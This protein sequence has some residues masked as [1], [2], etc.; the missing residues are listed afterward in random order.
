MAYRPTG[1]RYVPTIPEMLRHNAARHRARP[2]LR[3]WADGR[4][5]AISYGELLA[6]VEEFGAGLAALGLHKGDK[7]AIAAENGPRWAIAYLA[8]VAAGGIGVPIY[9]ELDDR[10]INGLI[11][12]S[13]SRFALLSSKV[14]D[15]TARHL[16]R[17]EAVIVTDRGP[18]GTSGELP[19]RR[20]L[21]H[22]QPPAAL[23]SFEEVLGR[24]TTESRAAFAQVPVRANDLAS[25]VYTSGTTGD[26]KGVMLSHRNIMSNAMAA[27][28]VVKANERDRFLQVLPM[29]HTF[30]FTTGLVAPLCAGA[31]VG[32]END[33]KRIR[34]RMFEMRATIFLG[35][36][37]L[38]AVMYRT[39]L[40]RIEAEGQMPAFQKGLALV[41]TVKRT[42]GVNI[43]RLVFR[44]LHQRLGGSIRLLASGGAALP[45]DVARRYA[46]LGILLIQGWGL[47]E[48]SPVC[49][50]PAFSPL[51]FYFTSHY[52]RHAASV[53]QALPGV[54]IS[55]ID[56][57]EKGIFAALHDEGELVVKGPN[58]TRGYYNNE[59]ATREIK[60]GEWLRTGDI[61]H[62][63]RE[64]NV[65]ITGRA[66]YVIVLSSGEKV[67]P[68]ELEER[69]EQSSLVGDICV[70][71][72]QVKKFLRGDRTEVVAVVYPDPIAVQ[73]RAASEGVAPTEEGIHRWVS[74]DIAR[75]QEDTPAY[76]TVTDVVL[77]DAPLPKTPLRK[78]RRG[79]V[80]GE[81]H[82]FDVRKF[83][84]TEA[85][86]Q[87]QTP[88]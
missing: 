35:V 53:G 72:R 24:A 49:A 42:T 15:K 85:E 44:A 64:G 71:G 67:Y 25:I 19:A 6:E 2:A 87:A 34:E 11:H 4:Y 41:E 52:E 59:A 70:V 36:P 65:Y 10:E 86:Q 33:L 88:A 51:K 12:E 48:A 27:I 74:E 63:D 60:I 62:I 23:L 29:H 20:H 18:E 26:P 58:V 55:M 30:P 76:K 7:V 38:F 47:T 79:L 21:F 28:P 5:R 32:F 68:D 43:G 37:A 82:A 17:L 1:D 45:P 39:I 77:T 69:L 78:I 54:E 8:T 31:S 46:A 61:G 75:L 16:P 14:L 40:S 50:A 13:G 80:G 3:S 66:K 22:R 57:P 9:G 56:V 83:L 81:G 84:Q 73:E